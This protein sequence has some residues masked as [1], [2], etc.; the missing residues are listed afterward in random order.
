MIQAVTTLAH[1]RSVVTVLGCG[2]ARRR[3]AGGVE[4]AALPD[5]DRGV[6]CLHR[7]RLG[8]R[9]SRRP[10]PVRVRLRRDP[11][12][13]RR[14]PRR[15]AVTRRIGATDAGQRGDLDG[16]ARRFGVRRGLYVSSAAA[17]RPDPR[18]HRGVDD[19]LRRVAQRHARRVVPVADRADA[20][21]SVGRR[22]RAGPGGIPGAARRRRAAVGDPSTTIFRSAGGR[23]PPTSSSCTRHR[24][25]VGG[26]HRSGRYLDVIG[27]LGRGEMGGRLRG[28][29]QRDSGGRRERGRR[30]H[31]DR[32]PGCAA[33]ASVPGDPGRYRRRRGGPARRTDRSR[34]G[35]GARRRGRAGVP[36]V[37]VLADAAGRRR[38]RTARTRRDLRS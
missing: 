30:R 28:A 14:R 23:R 16:D 35:P 8:D 13:A 1:R 9:R 10:V 15:P 5:G 11:A 24:R 3:A 20:A 19:R 32:L 7:S 4:P 33:V 25:L 27:R 12:S 21:R 2:C 38:G 18:R 36:V 34:R 37:H 31:G 22:H 6:A 26:Q 17:H 29:D